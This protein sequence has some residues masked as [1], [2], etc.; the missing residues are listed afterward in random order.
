MEEAVQ[1]ALHLKQHLEGFGIPKK[2]PM[3]IFEVNQSSISL[4]NCLS[5]W[6]LE[7]IRA[8]LKGT[9]S[10]QL[11]RILGGVRISVQTKAVNLIRNTKNFKQLVGSERIQVTRLK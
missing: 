11:A 10:A 9:D 2:Q 8:V 5:A 6:K 7:K 4:T 1:D 3:A